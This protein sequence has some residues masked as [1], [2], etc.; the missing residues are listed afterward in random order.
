MRARWLIGGALA[1][2]TL[3]RLLV[4]ARLELAPDEAYYALWAAHLQPGYYDHPPMVALF[5]RAGEAVFGKT[6][7]G[8]RLLAP[9]SALLGALLLWDAADRLFPAHKPGALAALLLN[10]TL[11]IGTG[12]IIITP[13]TPLLLFWSAALNAL[14]RVI[15]TGQPRWWLA[16][17]LAMGLALLSKYTALLFLIAAFFWLLSC[18]WG[19]A[20]LRTPWP[21]LAAALAL[22]VFAPDIAW[23]AAHHWVSY[24]KQGGRV[25]GF[26]PARSLQFLGELVGGQLGLLTPGIFVLALAGTWRLRHAAHP[27]ASLLLWLTL[28]PAAVMFEHVLTGRVQANW[29]AILYPSLLIAA[30]LPPAPALR[31]WVT[32]ALALGFALSGLVY[33]QALT[34][35]LPLPPRLDPIAL[36]LAG[37]RALTA[38]IAAEATALNA[39]YVTADNYALSAE[40]VFYGP[41]ALRVVGFTPRWSYFTGYA[42]A[43]VAGVAGLL[44]THSLTFPCHQLASLTRQAG[45]RVVQPY[46]VCALIPGKPGREI[47]H[48]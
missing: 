2:L 38:Q 25:D 20:R 29:M 41:P 40:L 15:E 24:A 31:R 22:L 32:P 46:R 18:P 5:I 39:P 3:L 36:Q 28:T 34:L 48:P 13:D 37:W 23:N 47:P 21:W 17:G 33:V 43:P 42:P 10:A 9:F 7:L 19:R 45:G 6:A 27:A 14:A 4:A 44:V 26:K 1:A 16:A 30:A 11:L 8:V 12:A 35:A